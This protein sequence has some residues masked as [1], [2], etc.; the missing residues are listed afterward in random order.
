MLQFKP[1]A[2]IALA[3]LAPIQAPCAAEF[4]D[5]DILPTVTSLDFLPDRIGIRIGENPSIRG[6]GGF[7]YVRKSASFLAV[8]GVE[9]AEL[10][11]ESVR[12]PIGRPPNVTADGAPYVPALCNEY[13]GGIQSELTIAGKPLA[14]DL[15][16][17]V[18]VS[19]VEVV[20]DTAWIGTYEQGGH[21]DYGAAGLL[22]VSMPS[23]RIVERVDTGNLA[24]R[25]VRLDPVAR[26]VWAITDDRMTVVQ[27]DTR[28]VSRYYFYHDFDPQTGRPVVRVSDVEVASHP[29]AVFAQYLPPTQQQAFYIALQSIPELVAR[30]FLLYEFFMCCDFHP[31]RNVPGELEF[32]LP[33]LV[34]AYEHNR[35]R[36]RDSLHAS[37]PWRQVACWLGESKDARRLCAIEDWADLA[38]IESVGQY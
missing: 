1:T 17:C 15:G 14:V 26:S 11:G 12:Q 16:D 19:E 21:G 34:I 5:E 10:V 33:Y 37:M 4:S 22:A 28:D 23:G 32:L 38:G 2:C 29:L 18:S 24:V 27:L 9:Y 36:Y 20:G 35:D 6:I 8:D 3:L 31:K 25:G 30:R 13:Q 7:V